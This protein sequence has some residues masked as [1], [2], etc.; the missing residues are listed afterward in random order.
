[1]TRRVLVIGGGFAG[2]SA[3]RAFERHR[4]GDDIR[5]TLVDR[6]NFMLFTPMLPEV[7]SGGVETRHVVQPHRRSLRH[8]AFEL[9]NLL[10]ADLA[11]RVVTIEHPLTKETRALPFDQLVLALGST[12]AT[13]GTPG[14]DRFTLTLKSIADAEQLRNRLLGALE[15]AAKTRDLL[16]RDR[17][18]RVVVVGGSFTGVEAAGELLAFW[19]SACAFYPDVDPTALDF[20]LVEAGE[21]LL[22]HLPEKFGKYAARSLRDRGVKI[23]LGQDVAS[24]DAQGVELKNGKRYGAATVLWSAGVEPAPVVKALGVRLSAHGA[25]VTN[26][27]FSVP[28]HPGVWAIGD[29][30]A[31][32]KPGGGTYAPL[33]QFAVR[34]GPLAAENVL[35]TLRG[36]AT[37]NFRYRKLGQMASLGARQGIAELPGNRM[38]TGLPAWL[39]WRAYYL[40]RLPG[41]K[42]KARVAVD[43]MLDFAGPSGLARLPLA[44]CGAHAPHWGDTCD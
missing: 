19:R 12:T 20:V 21:R 4:G 13:K 15:V 40:S 2:V 25:I 5:V 16:E 14:A 33:A 29:C 18:L 37:K 30:A 6:E 44:D 9:G 1:V 17:L 43:W 41:T 34:E 39:L 28:G 42:K 27:D 31:V 26:G 7:A 8:T 10:R 23:V 38:L 11:A 24:I 3:A 35:R 22:S 36:A 32:P